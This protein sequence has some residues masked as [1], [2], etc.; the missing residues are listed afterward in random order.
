MIENIIKR[1]TAVLLLVLTIAAISGWVSN[2]IALFAGQGSQSDIL[3]MLR[4]IGAFILPLGS[5]M[6]W[7]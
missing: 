1:T 7:L 2:L 5:L 6:G 4:I 3:W